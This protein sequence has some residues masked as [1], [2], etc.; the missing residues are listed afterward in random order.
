MI[1]RTV[2]FAPTCTS[3]KCAMCRFGTHITR[4]LSAFQIVLSKLWSFR[5]EIRD[6]FQLNVSRLLEVP[7]YANSLR[8]AMQRTRA[9]GDKRR[10]VDGVPVRRPLAPGC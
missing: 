1:R 9:P 6:N 2:A 8:P 4:E 10:I 7:Q 3:E 5:R